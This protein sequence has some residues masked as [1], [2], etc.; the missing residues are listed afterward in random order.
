MLVENRGSVCGAAG[1]ISDKPAG[2]C[3]HRL[4]AASSRLSTH[5]PSQSEQWKPFSFQ[6]RGFQKL[7]CPSFRGP[8]C[9]MNLIAR[10]DARVP[11]VAQPGPRLRPEARPGLFWFRAQGTLLKYGS[12]KI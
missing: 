2:F 9:N 4:G 12:L 1:W 7:R 10:A 5:R 8:G 11:D 6:I 3:V